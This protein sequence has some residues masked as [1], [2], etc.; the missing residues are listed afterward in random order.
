MTFNVHSTKSFSHQ[1]ECM[2]SSYDDDDDDDVGHDVGDDDYDDDY[3][4]DETKRMNYEYLC[5]MKH[6]NF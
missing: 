2:F 1:A 6:F 3:D 4:D 5:R